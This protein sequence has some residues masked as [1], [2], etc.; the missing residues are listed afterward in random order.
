M[1]ESTNGASLASGTFAGLMMFLDWVVKQK[2]A[3]PAAISP[4]K[5]AARQVVQTVEGNGNIDG[6]D[7]QSLDVDEYFSR[8]QVAMKASGR[9]NPDSVRAYRSRFTRALDLYTDYLTTGAKPKLTSRSAAA[10]RTRKEKATTSAPNAASP[11]A[12]SATPE[13]AEAP[14][15]NMISYPFPLENDE[16]ANL[17]LPKKL[18]PRDAARLTAFITALTFEPPKQLGTGRDPQPDS[19]PKTDS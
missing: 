10:V 1:S 4:L 13:P 19:G 2:Y 15:T 3:T 7:V 6:M 5:S 12:G 16:V 11:K 14:S 17:R 9:V 8:F 18:G